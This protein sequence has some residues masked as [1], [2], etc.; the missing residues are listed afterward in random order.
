MI[1]RVIVTEMDVYLVPTG[2]DRYELYCESAEEP[3][4]PHA[5]AGTGI[6]RRLQEKFS[7]VLAAVEREHEHSRSDS[8]GHAESGGYLSRLRTRTMRWLAE[9]V[10]EQRLLWRLQGQQQVRAFFPPS[11]G[12]GR[13]LAII[14][15]I[16][17]ADVD[18][19]SRWLVLDT[20]GLLF[21]LLLIPLP[22]PNL[23]GYYFTFRV[24]G[25][26]LAVR[27]GRHG[28]RRVAWRMHPSAPLEEL[29][30]LDGLP[31]A[32]RASRVRA[33]ADQLGLAKLARFF[34]RTAVE[35][36]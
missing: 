23:P 10:A 28:L 18:R 12:D 16:L 11:L 19:H 20:V 26:F 24:V 30:G 35:S 21:S 7:A 8:T 31:S 14:L 15:R 2:L 1:Q 32:E 4:I 13:A 25:H 9:R 33:V 6:W 27:G 5:G 17:S 29:A 3:S 34:E 36:A 22:G